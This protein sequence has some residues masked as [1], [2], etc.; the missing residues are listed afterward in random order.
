MDIV[1]IVGFLIGLFVAIQYSNSI[2]CPDCGCR[3]SRY[4]HCKN[5]GRQ[6]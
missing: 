1:I 3:T 2:K 4:S 5:C 6:T